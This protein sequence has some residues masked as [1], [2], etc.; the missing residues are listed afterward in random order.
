MFKSN[1][2]TKSLLY[3]GLY[4]SNRENRTDTTPFLQPWRTKCKQVPAVRLV[5]FPSQSW[6]EFYLT[7]FDAT[8]GCL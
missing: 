6:Y 5:H 2:N 3:I 4:D 1:V 7:F 8:D